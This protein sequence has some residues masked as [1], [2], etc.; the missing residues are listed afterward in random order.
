MSAWIQQ[1]SPRPGDQWRPIPLDKLEK[2]PYESEG[3]GVPDEIASELEKRDCFRIH[4]L[5]C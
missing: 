5:L 4:I 1:S 3:L 2:V